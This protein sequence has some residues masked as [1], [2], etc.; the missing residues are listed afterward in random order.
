MLTLIS[1]GIA[2]T[3][4]L[5]PLIRQRVAVISQPLTV[6]A[7]NVPGVGWLQVPL[8]GPGERLAVPHRSPSP[9]SARPHDPSPNSLNT[10]AGKPWAFLTCRSRPASSA[11]RCAAS[12]T[13][14]PRAARNST[15]PRSRTIVRQRDS[16]I[17]RRS[18]RSSSPADS[19]STSPVMATRSVAPERTEGARNASVNARFAVSISPTP[20]RGARRLDQQPPTNLTQRHHDRKEHSVPRTLR[21]PTST[22]GVTKSLIAT[23]TTNAPSRPAH[24]GYRGAGEQSARLA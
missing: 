2:K 18:H 19:R 12:N 9:P 22:T 1:Q 21:S 8:P 15:P 10:L 4:E 3:G 23:L 20:I 11:A 24:Q 16:A 7:R 13:D 5:C 17:T 14:T 6:I